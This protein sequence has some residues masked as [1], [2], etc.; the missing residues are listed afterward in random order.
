MIKSS[1]RFFFYFLFSIFFF[2]NCS[3]GS[4]RKK[5]VSKYKEISKL[6]DALPK[7]VLVPGGVYQIGGSIGSSFI[8]QREIRSITMNSFLISEAPF[9]NLELKK[10]SSF[11]LKGLK[12]AKHYK[13]LSSKE[14]FKKFNKIGF[15]DSLKN[16]YRDNPTFQDYPALLTYSQAELLCKIFSEIQV[17]FMEKKNKFDQKSDNKNQKNEKISNKKEEN[18]QINIEESSDLTKEFTEEEKF[19][20]KENDKL[21][22]DKIKE[23]KELEILEKENN[24]NLNKYNKENFIQ[25]TLPNLSQKEV[26]SNYN[27]GSY[28]KSKKTKE[29]YVEGALYGNLN[30]SP[31]YSEGP[32]KGQFSSL[33]KRQRGDYGKGLPGEKEDSGAPTESIFTR[34]ANSLGLRNN[35]GNFSVWLSTSAYPVLDDPEVDYNPSKEVNDS[36]KSV[37]D[38]KSIFSKK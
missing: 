27:A 8:P 25:F 18:N 7:M 19:K 26:A 30:C 20:K 16:E 36:E 12:N 5:I 23:E 28:Q 22:E 9:T 4:K 10:I 37:F 34:P 31:R 3:F 38:K 15:N 29:V 32:L 1:F 17:Y 2:K 35:Y 33:H 6:S 21:E 24:Y 14:G 11:C 13:E